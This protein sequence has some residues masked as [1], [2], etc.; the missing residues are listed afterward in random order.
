SV[1]AARAGTKAA[2]WQVRDGQ[3]T[4]T[5]EIAADYLTLRAAQA[6]LAILQGQAKSQ[7]DTLQIVNARRQAGFVTELDVNQQQ[8]LLASTNAQIP[9]LVAQTR[10]MEHAIAV[11]LAAQPEAMAQELDSTAPLP[12]IPDQLP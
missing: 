6:R 1:E 12:T 2:Q 11:L 8:A 4:L 3:V 7:A 10:V 9:Q 5:A